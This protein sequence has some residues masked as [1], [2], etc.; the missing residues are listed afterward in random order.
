MPGGLLDRLQDYLTPEVIQ[1]TSAFLHE[2]PASTGRAVQMAVPTILRGL[3]E[4]SSTPSGAEELLEVINHMGTRIDLAAMPAFVDLV[5]RGRGLPSAIFCGSFASVIERLGTSSG[6]RAASAS[7]LLSLLTT[8]VMGVLAGEVASDG[9]DATGL[10]SRLKSQRSEI[11]P[12]V[13]AGLEELIVTSNQAATAAA[14]APPPLD[15][16]LDVLGALDALAGVG[17]PPSSPS[18]SPPSPPSPPLPRAAPEW[19]VPAIVVAL[20]A[21]LAWYLASARN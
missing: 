7:S 1:Q 2:S 11:D 10:A 3:I 12:F 16:S 18:S 5:N 17:R 6:L 19:A 14:A 20:V 8:M 9:L 13:P 21:L 4:W 15:D